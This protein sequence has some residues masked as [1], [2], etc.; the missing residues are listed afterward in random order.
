MVEKDAHVPPAPD[1]GADAA[2][3]PGAEDDGGAAGPARG[4]KTA[5]G[6]KTG[7]STTVEGSATS[8]GKT[9]QDGATGEGH[10]ARGAATGTDGAEALDA[11]LGLDDAVSALEAEIEGL[12]DRLAR[13]LADYD[14]LQK[15]V[16][17]D[18]AFER[19]RVKARVLEAF[20]QV[21]E[22]SKMAEFEAQRSPGPLAEGVKMM[23]REFDRMLEAEG[24]R[25][26]GAVGEPFDPRLHEAVAHE[27]AAGVAPGDISRVIATGYR[28]GDR[29]LRYAKVA[30]APDEPA[31]ADG[32]AG[33]AVEMS[34]ESE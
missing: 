28:L 10:T 30:V 4:G 12:R 3:A 33:G 16:A 18:A 17:R 5:E 15:R 9:A 13:A 29:V 32:P 34:A 8:R 1:G 20:L 2:S 27:P 31:P 24:L 26:L 23:V 11:S 14:N 7:R 22:Y 21:Y 25:P 19:E 6:G